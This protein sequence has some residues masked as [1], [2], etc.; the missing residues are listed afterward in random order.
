MRLE[1]GG[2]GAVAEGGAHRRA[3]LASTPAAPHPPS[4][5]RSRQHDEPAQE[6]GPAACALGVGR[7]SEQ[8]S[9]AGLGA[10][11]PLKSLP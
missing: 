7:A 10:Q 4:C 11:P 1:G 5:D 6:A 2:R 8:R 3:R 9:S